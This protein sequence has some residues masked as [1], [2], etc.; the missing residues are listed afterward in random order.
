[1]PMRGRTVAITGG[2]R[3]IGRATAQACADAG[4]T[5]AI[6]DIDTDPTRDTAAE[7][8]V[9][10]LHLDVTDPQSFATFLEQVETRL[11]PLDALVNNAGI[12]PTGPFAAETPA[13]TH[14]QL[15]INIHGVLT[16]SR[17]AAERF[18]AR[19]A[20]HL[21]NIA[22]L[23]GVTGEAGVATYCGTKHFVVGFTEA[24]HRELAPS[25]I[26]VTT[27]LPGIINTELAHGT[28]VPPWARSIACA[29]PD[30]VAAAIVRALTTRRAK[31][32]VPRTLGALLK[33]TSVLPDRARF[34]IAHALRLDN[35]AHGADPTQRAT[36]HHRITTDT[37]DQS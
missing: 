1:M 26:R 10:G 23:A 17:L 22:S 29:E 25:G 6:G 4:A 31:I 24:L 2:A 20:G 16:G 28:Q 33:T 36:Y 35:L 5:V 13:M 8:G 15:A 30:D 37:P 12:M 21:V 19:R 11:G 32:T 3:G 14:R 34:A 7:L 9:T 18:Q 27:V